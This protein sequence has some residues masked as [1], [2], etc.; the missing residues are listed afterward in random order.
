MTPLAT[1]L[2]EL[3]YDKLEEFVEIWAERKC[4]DYKSVERI[5]Q[6]NDKGRDVVGFLSRSMYEGE[7]D[8]YQ[9]KRKTI[10]SKLEVGEVL[11][12]IG[13]V[14]VH[15]LAGAF[16]TL[17]SRFIFV[18][19]RGLSSTLTHLSGHPSQLK[20]DLFEH[21]D[22]HCAS[23]I[24]HKHTYE[25]TDK[26]KALIEGYNFENFEWM[27][28]TTIVKD[29]AAKPALVQ[30]LDL[31]PDHA[32]RGITPEAISDT[33]LVYL[34]QLKGVYEK[35]ADSPFEDFDAVYADTKFGSHLAL[36][37]DRFYDA[38]SFRDFHRD[39]TD[40]MAVDTFKADIYHLL[41]EV[42][43][44]TH[45]SLMKRMDAVMIHIGTAH[46]DIR[47]RIARGAVKQGTCHHLVSDGRIH[48]I[49]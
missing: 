12:E 3:P 25:M 19:P 16:A 46:A 33:E 42:Y 26:L 22:T 30:L 13:K 7:W 31:M 1:K 14:F 11:V 47:G 41:Y 15:H 44:G 49:K 18:S 20:A 23:K 34:N 17:P 36:Q 21:W 48:W 29:P 39:N 6:A 40:A 24:K 28:A 27:K 32:P 10:G 4:K 9:C 35:E 43:H 8:L 37:R 45:A 2:Q 38:C 5:G